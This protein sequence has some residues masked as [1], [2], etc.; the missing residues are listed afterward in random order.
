MAGSPAVVND[1][2]GSFQKRGS[3]GRLVVGADHESGDQ[4]LDVITLT[5]FANE[6]DDLMTLLDGTTNESGSDETRRSGDGYLHERIVRPCHLKSLKSGC[7]QGVQPG[8]KAPRLREILREHLEWDLREKGSRD[9]LYRSRSTETLRKIR[10]TTT[11]RW[12]SG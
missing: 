11:E 10:N 2:I 8:L 4:I 9:K 12:R 3:G 5:G 6:G 1:D 7:R